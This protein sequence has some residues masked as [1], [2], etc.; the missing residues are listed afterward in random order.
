[1]PIRS[2][3]SGRAPGWRR[4]CA[5]WWQER[6]QSRDAAKWCIAPRAAV[7]TE[8]VLEEGMQ[9]ATAVR[10]QERWTLE[11]EMPADWPALVRRL[12]A[13][14]F[15]SPLGLRAGAPEGDPIFGRFYRDGEV[16]GIVAGVRTPCRLG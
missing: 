5:R 16:M 13:G 2:R 7:G 10:H 1:M 3:R 14:F 6:R 15:H 9:T 12:D 4:T 8:L 11:P